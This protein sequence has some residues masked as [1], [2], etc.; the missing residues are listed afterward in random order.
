[1][2][3]RR[4]VEDLTVE[5]LKEVLITRRREERLVRLRRMGA[6]GRVGNT[7]IVRDEQDPE[8]LLPP[9]PIPSVAVGGWGSVP[10]SDPDL[11][12]GGSLS[13]GKIRIWR[14]R[15]LLCIESA[16]LIGLIVVIINLAISVRSL[17]QDWQEQRDTYALPTLTPTPLIRVSILPGGHKPPTMRGGEGQ[18]LGPVPLMTLPTPG[19]RS[20]TRLVIPSINVDVNVVEGDDWEQL[21]KGAG[22]HIGSANPGERGNTFISG[23]N[24]VY[25]EVFRYLEDVQVGDEVIVYAGDQ[26]YRY[27]VRV[28]PRVV[29]PDDV[30]VMYPTSKAIVTLLTCYPYMIDTHRIVVIAELERQNTG[31]QLL[32]G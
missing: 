19:P 1:M 23:H 8:Y 12:R 32:N 16:A 26:P 25:G 31:L 2:R 18:P 29:E 22:H 7:V 27:I 3:D 6:T 4:Y 11:A 30:S 17:N 15:I 13:G 5:E 14:E 21:K 20:P 24:D 10:V 28:P 9:G